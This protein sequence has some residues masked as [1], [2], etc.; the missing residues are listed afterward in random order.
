MNLLEATIVLSALFCSLVAGFVFAFAIVAMPGIQSLNDREFLRAFKAMDSI[1]QRNQPLFMVVW[2]GSVV[3]LVIAAVLSFWRLDGLDRM[4]ILLAA[5]IYIFGVQ[6]P[7]VTVNVPL[8]N[9]LQ[10]QDLDTLTESLLRKAR[11]A[12]ADRWIRWNTIRTVFAILT[13]A[14]LIILLFRL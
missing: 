2:I 7:T 10:T 13:S 4:L 9:Q 1:I 5:A 12:F 3:A 14:L 11:I 8:N 6:L